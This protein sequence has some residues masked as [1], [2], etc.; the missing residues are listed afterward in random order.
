VHCRTQRRLIAGANSGGP[1][2]A[3]IMGGRRGG[4]GPD[5]ASETEAQH[6]RR[7]ISQC[8]GAPLMPIFDQGYQHWSGQLSGHAW[9]WLAITRRGVKTALQG[10]IVKFAL[11]LA[12]LPAIVLVVVL[13]LW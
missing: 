6:A 5:S 7:S 9:R 10:R 2:P 4:A 1:F 3:D 12:Y 11:I 8:G 13:C